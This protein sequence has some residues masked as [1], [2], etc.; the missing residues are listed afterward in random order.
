MPL[1]NVPAPAVAHYS[2]MQRLQ[3]RAVTR[4]RRGWS[5]IDP[6]HL[7]ESWRA[8]LPLVALGIGDAQLDAAIASTGYG[9]ATLARRREYEFPAA[10][11]DPTAF[12]GVMDDGGDLTAA[13]Y[14]PII[15]TKRALAGGASLPAALS[16]G[17]GRLDQLAHSIITDTGRAAASVDVASRTAIGYTRMLNPPSCDRCAILAGRWYRWNAGFDR[18]P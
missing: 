10:F 4:A 2:T 3:R 15:T 5:Q 17:R 12:V 18:H 16:V 9:A 8:V 11:V 13:L 6:R 14:S 7:S 1:Q